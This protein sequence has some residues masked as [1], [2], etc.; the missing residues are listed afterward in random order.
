[1]PQLVAAEKWDGHL[2]TTMPPGGSVPFLSLSG[3]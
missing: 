3:H 2:P 1:M